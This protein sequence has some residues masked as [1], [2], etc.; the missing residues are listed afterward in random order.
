MIEAAKEISK[1]IREAGSIPVAYMTWAEKENEAGQQQMTDAYRRM[2]VET[3]AVLAPVGEE[4]WKYKHAHPEVEMYA[5]DGEHA[6]LEGSTLA[7]R[8]LLEAIQEKE[9]E[10]ER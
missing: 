2:A 6:S 8:I 10:K 1:W 4:W 9:Q 5:S 7:A 3:G